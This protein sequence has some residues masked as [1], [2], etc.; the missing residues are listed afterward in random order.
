MKEALQYIDAKIYDINNTINR[1][2]VK[3]IDDR[4]YMSKNILSNLRYL[5]EYCFFRVY[6]TDEIKGYIK[7]N[8]ENN[9]QSIKHMKKCADMRELRAL[10]GFLQISTSHS[11]PNGDGSS[12]VMIKYLSYLIELKNFMFNKYGINILDNLYSFPLNVEKNMEVYYQQISEHVK[13][14]IFN[15]NK[16]VIA[17]QY[18]VRK[19]KPIIID[20]SVF[21]EVTLTDA[22]DYINKFNRIV[23]YSKEKIMDNYA[24]KISSVNRTIELF[25]RNVNIKIIDNYKI[26]IR[27]CELN[28]Y[29]KI[30]GLQY[31][32]SSKYGEYDLFMKY[33]RD[34]KCS[35]LDIVELNEANYFDFKEKMI[36]GAN[37]HYIIDLI[38]LSR[39]IVLNG[40]SG[41]NILKYFLFQLNN[42]VIRSQLNYNQ[43]FKLSNLYL[44]WGSIPFD[45]MPYASSLQNH[46]VDINDLLQCIDINNRE[47]ELL[48]RRLHY[49]SDSLG[50]IYNNLKDFDLSSEEIDELINRFNSKLYLPLHDGRKIIKDYKYIY[51]KG[52]ET[53]TISIIETLNELAIDGYEDYDN[54]FA[55]WEIFTDYVF[56]DSKKYDICKNIFVNSKVALLYGSAGCGKTETIK[57]ISSIFEYRN[58]VFLAKTNSAIENLKRRIGTSNSNFTFIT[59]DKYKS[60]PLSCDLL[61][62][63]E[64]STVDNYDM[65]KILGGTDKYDLLLLVGDIYQIESIKFGNWFRFA[66]ELLPTQCINELDGTFRT[67]DPIILDLWKK[68][69]NIDNDIIEYL[70]DYDMSDSL[71]K[72]IFNKNGDDEIILCL[73][74]DGPYGINSI[75]RYLQTDNPN[76]VYEWGINSYKVG[77]PVLFNDLNR[78]YPVLYNNLKGK[79]VN[80]QKS[81]EK[82]SFD[83]LVNVVITDIMASFVGLEIVERNETETTIRFSVNSNYDDDVEDKKDC[84]VPFVIAYATSIHKSQGLEYQSVKIVLNDEIGDVV[85]HNIFYTAITRTK[86]RLKIFWTPECMNK[87]IGNFMIK[88]NDDIIIIKNKMNI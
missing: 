31:K 88:N 79:I 21:Y 60:N 66:K 68:V 36:S 1:I 10:H 35:L 2:I 15:K 13:K 81:D 59:I 41:S 19:V 69:R 83:I 49:N 47:D 80:I 85:T 67:N 58:I 82:I 53:E 24:I 32:I 40:K 48:S 62:I 30:F 7:F 6:I 39:N 63:D 57:I 87:I 77:D 8:H 84:V 38:D 78:F 74:Y 9:Q 44:S 42:I 55:G 26:A 23:V 72:D 70:S 51:I 64:C 27:P 43:N 5:V 29:A 50:I 28:N 46:K 75:N 3:N 14:V 17:N 4:D 73:N 86:E 45:Q 33:L 18:Y 56:T 61:V 12:R 22:T 25:G 65:N 11:L 16:G 37:T 71:N 20:K 54:I 34:N 76:P 52:Y